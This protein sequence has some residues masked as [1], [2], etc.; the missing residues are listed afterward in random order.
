MEDVLIT[1]VVATYN[2]EDHIRRCLMGLVGQRD[3]GGVLEILVIDGGSRDGTVRIVE[4]LASRD[5]RIT[6]IENPNRF[7][8]YAWNIGIRRGRGRYI[9]LINAHTE[10]SADYFSCCLEALQ[11]SGAAN[12]SGVQTPIGTGLLGRAIAWAMQS[13]FGVGDAEFRYAREE[14]FV[15]HGFS[16]F[17]EKETAELIGGFDEAL[18]VNED[19]DFNYRLRKAG[20]RIFLSPR[21]RVTYRP[22]ATLHGLARQMFR[23]GFWRRKTQLRYPDYVPLRV[24]VPPLFVCSMLLSALAFG[25]S[26]GKTAF[27]TP[28]LYCVFLI[29]ASVR[30]AQTTRSLPVAGWI[31]VVVTTMHSSYG[32]GW[33]IGAVVHRAEARVV[34]VAHAESP[35][36]ATGPP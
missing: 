15:D 19:G 36:F 35:S 24:Y 17:F 3:V 16:F 7:Q 6:L 9:A 31:P 11:R 20:M 32:V 26:G 13:K 1:A 2:E 23:Y 18:P 10:Y 14:R 34:S 28:S 5:R 25:R 22:R 12:V 29:V 27:L 21:I 33:L 8:V 30:A 4:E